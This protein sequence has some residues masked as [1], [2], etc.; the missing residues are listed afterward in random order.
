MASSLGFD[1]FAFRADPRDQLRASLFAI[2]PA[3][4]AT[5]GATQVPTLDLGAA[6][7]AVDHGTPTWVN[8]TADGTSRRRRSRTA[9]T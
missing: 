6:H 2:Q 8:E 1:G 5:F 4:G 3:G 7:W 9:E